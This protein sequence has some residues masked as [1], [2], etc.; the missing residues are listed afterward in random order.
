VVSRLF[1]RSKAGHTG[2][3]DPLATGMLPILLGEATRFSRFGLAADKIYEFCLDLSLQTDTLDSEGGVVQHFDVPDFKLP[4]IQEATG[5]LSSRTEQQPPAYSAIRVGGKHAYDLARQGRPVCLSP[6]A[7]TIHDLQLINW[8]KPLLHLRVH[9]SKGTYVRSLARDLG[10]LLHVGGCVISLRRVSIGCW[11]EDLMVGIDVLEEQRDSALKPLSCWL[12]GVP[13]LDLEDDLARR[14]LHGQRLPV[15][16]LDQD[17][18]A[19]YH[20]GVLLGIAEVRD[21]EDMSVLHPQCVLPS[22]QRRFL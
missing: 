4:A 21:V 16:M 1:D 6:R 15:A 9:C 12:S 18:V 22:A 11:G 13:G 3:L 14:F 5:I 17:E 7:V 8:K 2:T 19:V 10:E 20:R